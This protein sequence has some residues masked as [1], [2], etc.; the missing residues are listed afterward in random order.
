MEMPCFGTESAPVW[1]F[2]MLGILS[3][4]RGAVLLLREARL[5]FRK[6]RPG[7]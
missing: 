3:H 1:L 2:V 6:E 4:A 5:W 7:D